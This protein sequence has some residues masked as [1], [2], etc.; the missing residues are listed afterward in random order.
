MPNSSIQLKRSL[1]T[2]DGTFHADEVTASALLITFDLIDKNKIVRT[3]NLDELNKCEFV[4]DVGGVFDAA[5]KKFDHHQSGYTGTLSSAGMIL[6]YLLEEE[7]INDSLY[8]FINDSLVHGVDLHDNGLVSLERG[9]CSFSGVVSNFAPIKYGA[10]NSVTEDAFYKALD[11]VIAHIDRLLQRYKYNLS[12]KESVAQAMDT[13]EKYLVFDAPMPWMESF[14]E[15]GGNEHQAEYLIMPT[16]DHW[17]LRGI[18]PTFQER[19][20][21]RKPLPEKWAGLL[22]EELE[23]VSGIPGSIFCHKGRFISV[24]KTR[25]DALLALEKSL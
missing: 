4:C 12:C 20:Q 16:G 25:K 10:S 11:F 5:S 17:K 18:P 2:H 7:I 23:K 8:T 19:M 14:F 1:G 15:L 22:G 6:K 9:H 3:R 13:K 24:W 21:V